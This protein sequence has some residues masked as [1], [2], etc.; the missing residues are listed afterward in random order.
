MD[1]K[2]F[3][4]TY[5]GLAVQSGRPTRLNQVELNLRAGKD[6]A[7]LLFFGDLHFGHP[8]CD[9][10]KAKA[11]LDWAL[12]NKVAVLLMGDMVEAGLRSSIGD[13]V[14]QQ[15]FNPQKQMEAV[16]KLLMPL[17]K[18][19]LIIGLHSGNHEQRI[20]QNTGIDISKIM[21]NLLHVKYLGYACWSMLTVGKQKYSMYSCH[22]KSGARFKHTKLKAVADL[23]GWLK[24]DIIAHAHVHSIAAEPAMYQEVDFR[25]RVVRDGKCYVVLTGS[26]LK[27]DR[28]YAQDANYPIT[29]IGSPK[30][31]IGGVEHDMHFSL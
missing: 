6:Y 18:A 14:Y 3:I 12:E 31:M 10:Q 7:E 19:K 21:A 16:V 25:N 30:A 11:M 28:S 27:W 20:S 17:A 15:K 22:G 1:K 29:R 2:K 8:Q 5:G 26:Y 24:A 13:S 9:I 23:T 4:T